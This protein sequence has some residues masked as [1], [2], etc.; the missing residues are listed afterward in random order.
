MTV[1]VRLT[2]NRRS[3]RT[4]GCTSRA[5]RRSPL[6]QGDGPRTALLERFREESGPVL[7]G[8]DSFWEGV[9]VRGS[10]LQSVVI[11]RLPF[12]VPTEPLV[13]ARTE[14][15]QARGGNAFAEVTIPD[16]VIR[17]KQGFGRLIRHRTDR[18]SLLVLDRRVATRGYGRQFIQALPEGIR[19]VRGSW[20]ALKPQLQDFHASIG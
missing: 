8:T 6:R 19:V 11:T 5:L 12:R 9:D 7:F 18:G 4:G 16:A 15:V 3:R 14:A 20:A 17:F 10:A 1:V 13:Q 2:C